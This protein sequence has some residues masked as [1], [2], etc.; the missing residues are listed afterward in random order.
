MDADTPPWVALGIDQLRLTLGPA[1]QLA[2]RGGPR[3]LRRASEQVVKVPLVRPSNA[4]IELECRDFVGSVSSPVRARANATR[5]LRPRLR[6]MSR[7]EAPRAAASMRSPPSST[8]IRRRGFFASSPLRFFSRND[9]QS[10]LCTASAFTLPTRNPSEGGRMAAVIW[11][12][13]A[14][15]RHPNAACSSASA[16]VRTNG[17][18][19]GDRFMASFERMFRGCSTPMATR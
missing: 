10:S 8:A 5:E 6:R 17:C 12:T 16:G 11:A 9:L 4:R 2:L 1:S 3:N 18:S 19:Q 13:L 7:V 15:W 14:G